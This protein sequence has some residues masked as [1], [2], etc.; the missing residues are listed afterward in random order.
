LEVLV[1]FFAATSVIL[2]SAFLSPGQGEYLNSVPVAVSLLFLVP[3]YS[4]YRRQ[5]RNGHLS[6]EVVVKSKG[7][8]IFWVSIVFILAV[9]TRIPSVL[10]WG[11]P[12]E[13]TPVIL[14]V[15]LTI[16]L[17]EKTEP[18]AFGFT[19]RKFGLGL[20]Y[21]LSFLFLLNGL[22]TGLTFL[23]I[24]AS[25]GQASVQAYNVSSFLFGLPFMTLCVGL[26]EEGLFRGYIQS[27][28]E[29]S[30]TAT[31]AIIG[32]AILFGAWHFVWNISPLDASAMVQY[33][34]TTAFIGLFFG[35]FYGK[36][37]NLT[38]LVLA[39]GL[40]DSIG[41]GIVEN[42]S[43]FD[44]LRRTASLTQFSVLFFPYLVSG[45]LTFAF[46]K[47]SVRWIN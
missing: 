26:S 35:Y 10:V 38:P 16:I 15:V 1:V 39:H 7:T 14:L 27:H 40:W 20:V 5:R 47:Y 2:S 23:L 36:T 24:Y 43:A 25:T 12:Y 3:L 37:R 28:L 17:V 41:L 42:P 34:T 32:Q 4:W 45:V 21:G 13:K 46:L 11:V 6:K 44:A 18:A 8:V 31:T 33:V 30:F 19:T 29:K 22:T 9:A